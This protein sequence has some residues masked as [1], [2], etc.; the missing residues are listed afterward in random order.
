MRPLI[1]IA[2]AVIAGVCVQGQAQPAPRQVRAIVGGTLI[3]GTGAAPRPNGVILIENG[4]IARIGSRDAIRLAPEDA[5]INADGKYILPGFIDAHIHYRDYYPELLITH[6]VTAAAE[7][8]GSPLPWILAQRD[9]IAAGQ[10][11]GPRLFTCGD[12]YSEEAED[13]TPEKAAQWLARMVAAGVDKID[14]GFASPPPVLKVL[15][16][17]GHKAGLPVSGYPAYINE[18]IA[19]GIDSIKH[20]YSVG[21]AS[22]TDP[23]LLEDIRRQAQ[24]PYRK[25]DIALPLVGPA[26]RALAARLVEHHVQWVPTLVKDFKVIHDR[27]DEFEVEGMRLLADPNLDYLPREDMFLMTSNRFGVGMATPGGTHFEGLVKRR[28]D[29]IDYHSAAFRTYHDAY[30]NLQRLIREIVQGGGHV[31]AGTAPHSYVLPGLSLHQEMQLFVDAGLSP[32][33]ALQSAGLWVAQYLKKD[34]DLGTVETGKLADII[35]LDANPL[36]D[37]RNTRTVSAVLQGG[38]QL[39]LG[40][41]FTFRNPIPRSTQ[42]TAPGAASPTPLLA[43]VSRES[44]QR[45]S[46]PLEVELKGELFTDG[47]LA[48][49]DDTALPTTFV[50]PQKLR[51]AIPAA[52]LDDVG[53]HWL[54]VF[55]PPPGRVASRPLPLIVRY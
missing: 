3:D 49:F 51:A 43:S 42:T 24:L 18:A 33:Q 10:L 11:F 15:I 9:G 46:G 6:G 1:G 54:R 34:R 37:I 27:R 30:G 19:L 47:A 16:E 29:P 17:G 26:S 2:V 8:G 55:N 14:I 4:R 40:Y 45:G 12:S 41:H 50:S 53:T 35:V 31:L 25:R 22:Q 32:M 7:W 36:A 44:A 20:T 21:I 23:A 5:V 13:Q 39:P 38:R 48:Y 28:S 52:L